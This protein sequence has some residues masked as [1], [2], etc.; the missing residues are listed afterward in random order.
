MNASALSLAIKN[1]VATISNGLR[2][3]SQSV[4]NITEG[5]ADLKLGQDLT[6]KHLQDERH[7]R[8]VDWLSPLNMT[9]KHNDTSSRRQAGTGLWLL[10]HDLY[11]AWLIGTERVLWCQGIRTFSF[12]SPSR[13]TLC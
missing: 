10:E 5:V 4:S 6:F 9:Y 12:A 13:L 2:I 11:K 7:Q 3:T 1:D 8:I